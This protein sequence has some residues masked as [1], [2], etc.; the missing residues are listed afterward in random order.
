MPWSLLIRGDVLM[1]TFGEVAPGRL[2]NIPAPGD[3]PF[4]D[5]PDF[6]LDKSTVSLGRFI[7]TRFWITKASNYGHT[8][9]SPTRYT[10]DY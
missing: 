6:I 9:N 7:H 1:L 5:L 2:V 10:S 8:L 4:P 3:E